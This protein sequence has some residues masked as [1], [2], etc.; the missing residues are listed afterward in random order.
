MNNI[1]K[2]ETIAQD[3]RDIRDNHPCDSEDDGCLCAQFDHAID[4]VELVLTEVI[5]LELKYIEQVCLPEL[6]GPED[7][8][9]RDATTMELTRL[10]GRLAQLSPKLNNA[11]VSTLTTPVIAFPDDSLSLEEDCDEWSLEQYDDWERINVP[12][13]IFNENTLEMDPEALK[14]A[15]KLHLT[16]S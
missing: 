1:K 16:K 15:V 10:E 7:K 6:E 4:K 8:H 11:A 5:K 3:I 14:L 13:V 9:E 12:D 2:L